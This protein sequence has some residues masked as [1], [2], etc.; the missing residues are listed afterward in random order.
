M[1]GA[2]QALRSWKDCSSSWNT[3]KKHHSLCQCCQSLRTSC[4]NPPMPAA[5][6]EELN[7]TWRWGAVGS[8]SWAFISS[9]SPGF[10]RQFCEVPASFSNCWYLQ[11][12]EGGNWL[13]ST[14]TSYSSMD[15]RYPGEER[16]YRILQQ[17]P[18]ACHWKFRPHRQELEKFWWELAILSLDLSTFCL[19]ERGR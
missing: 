3:K 17:R 11:W 8:M 1:C 13:W 12:I 4:Q 19:P 6:T 9:S 2:T 5:E 15:T 7:G 10:G 16:W 14:S 18:M